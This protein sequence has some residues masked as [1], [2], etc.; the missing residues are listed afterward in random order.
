MGKCYEVTAIIRAT[1][2]NSEFYQFVDK[3]RIGGLI[4]EEVLDTAEQAFLD[5][6]DTDLMEVVDVILVDIKEL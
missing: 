6:H 5:K 2:A 1:E 3:L 4:K